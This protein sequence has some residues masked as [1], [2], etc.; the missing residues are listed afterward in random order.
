MFCDICQSRRPRM[1][2]LCTIFPCPSQSTDSALRLWRVQVEDHT[3]RF[4]LQLPVS[5]RKI[6]F[7]FDMDRDSL[8]SIASEMVEELSLSADQAKA[9]ASKIQTEIGCLKEVGEAMVLPG[10]ALYR[11]ELRAMWQQA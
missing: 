10:A 3:L 8:D 7:A 4:Q 5:S 2:H 9:I 11:L 6:E 1:Q